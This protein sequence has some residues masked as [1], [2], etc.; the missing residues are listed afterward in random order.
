MKCLIIAAGHGSRLQ[1]IGPSKP[2]VEVSGVPLIEHV[3]HRAIKG[4]A[5]EFVV[6]TGHA[7][8]RVETFLAALAERLGVVIGTVRTPDWNLP[9]GHSILAASSL[10]GDE[11]HVLLM[12]DHL[13]DPAILERLIATHGGA[14]GLTLAIDRRLDNPLVDL[15]D[16]TRVRV[17]D[18][19]GITD[20]GKSLAAYNAFDTGLF[21]AG[22]TLHT[23]LRQTTAAGRGSL[24]DG[25]KLL[26]GQGLAQT[27][28]IGD[29]WWIDVDDPPTFALCSA[30]LGNAG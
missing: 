10:L 1:A 13:F 4:G 19:G 5:T 14:P 18:N 6:V 15:E 12:S 17:D 2:L 22:A 7:A 25:V 24:S 11:T 29:G 23:A 27:M 26:A 28:D 16:V 3:V 21:V 8:E 30:A 20:I 9:N